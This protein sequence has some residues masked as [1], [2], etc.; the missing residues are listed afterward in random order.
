MVRRTS[1]TFSVPSTATDKLEPGLTPPITVEVAGS[2]LM[3]PAVVMTL[4]VA[5]EP[6]PIPEVTEVTVP[7]LTVVIYPPAEMARPVLGI[8]PPTVVVVATGTAMPTND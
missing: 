3:V 2:R 8:T 1:P 5:G 7:L 4:P 6:R